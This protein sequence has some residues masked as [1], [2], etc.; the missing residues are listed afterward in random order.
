MNGDFFVKQYSIIINNPFWKEVFC[1]FHHFIANYNHAFSNDYYLILYQPIWNNSL[2]K[3]D[4]HPVSYRHWFERGV[5]IINDLISEDGTFFNYN[6]FVNILR[7]NFWEYY[8]LIKSIKSSWKNIFETLDY[9]LSRPAINFYWLLRLK[10]KFICR[11][12]YNNLLRPSVV[13]NKALV[14]WRN[15]MNTDISEEDWSLYCS[16][17]FKCSNDV[18]IRWF[19]YKIIHRLIPCNYYLYII[20]AVDSDKSEFCHSTI[21]TIEHLFFH[22]PFVRIL[23]EFLNNILTNADIDFNI[24]MV[25]VV[26]FGCNRDRMFNLIII[27][28]KHYIFKCKHAKMYPSVCGLLDSLKEYFSLQKFKSKLKKDWEKYWVPWANLLGINIDNY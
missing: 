9:S 26:V 18:T 17:P 11:S 27:L 7:S 21:E 8:G 12:V 10:Q 14:K 25:E 23:W 5:H 22:C 15:K 19:Q 1:S 28:V 3:V 6:E 4:N 16:I 2:I 13:I 20:R 24:H